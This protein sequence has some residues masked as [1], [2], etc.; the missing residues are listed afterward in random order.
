VLVEP[1]V[2]ALLALG[3]MTHSISIL[4]TD[5]AGLIAGFLD[6]SEI[7]AAYHRVTSKAVG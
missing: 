5:E 2:L 7:H 1:V 4:E 6:A 3:T